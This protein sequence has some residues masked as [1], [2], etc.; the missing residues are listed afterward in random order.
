MAPSLARRNAVFQSPRRFAAV[1]CKRLLRRRFRR[2]ANH[3]LNEDRLSADGRP[4]SRPSMLMSSSRSGQWIPVPAPT[5]RQFRRSSV[6]PRCSRG[7][8]ES[9][10]SS[11]LPSVSS[12]MI[13]SRVT[14]TFFARRGAVSL[15][16]VRIPGPQYCLAIGEYKPMHA[17]QLNPV[18]P[19][20]LIKSHRLQPELGDGVVPLHVDVAWLDAIPCVEEESVRADTQDRGHRRP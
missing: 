14:R 17:L 15:G 2:D 5:R 7:Y 19:M 13:E 16:E 1:G 6:V 9:G 12:T 4:A 10:T 8:Q 11:V 18:E 3:C 20:A